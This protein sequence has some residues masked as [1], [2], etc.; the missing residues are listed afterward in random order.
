MRIQSSAIGMDSARSYKASRTGYNRF[1]LKD[2]VQGGMNTGTGVAGQQLGMG[3]MKGQTAQG[4]SG[5][6]E[7]QSRMIS[8]GGMMDLRER[9]ESMMNAG[10]VHLRGGSE[11]AVGKLRNYTMRYIF[12]LLFGDDRTRNFMGEDESLTEGNGQEGQGNQNGQNNQ[13][14]NATLQFLPFDMKTLSYGVEEYYSEQENTLFSSV[15]TVR[16]ADGREIS[17]HVDLSMSRSFTQYYRRELN[18]ASLQKTCDP[19]VINFDVGNV[20]LSDQKFRFD[21]D[22]DG[23]EDNVSML[24]AGSGYLALDKN[25]DGII[26]DGSE[27]FGPQSGNGFQDLSAYDE[28]GNGWID[29]NDSIWSKLKIWCKNPDGTD[30]LYTLGEKGVGAICLQNTATDFSLKGSGGQ[31]NGYIRNTGIFLYENGNVGTVQHLDLVQ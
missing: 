31:D 18:L 15:G 7:K 21:I 5:G 3:N 2:Y 4:G 6:D 30:S 25:G 13:N 12:M 29:E 9:V 28:D 26:N 10:R 17:F 11:N 16:T 24:G 27:L 1:V 8:T 23:Q 20:S 22:A 14:G 19:L